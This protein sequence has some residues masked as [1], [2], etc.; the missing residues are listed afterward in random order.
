[1]IGA[2]AGWPRSP[3]TGGSLV[4]IGTDSGFSPL[5]LLLPSAI[6]MIFTILIMTDSSIGIGSI[7]IDSLIA[8]PGSLAIITRSFGMEIPAHV[9]GFL[10]VPPDPARASRNGLAPGPET[11]PL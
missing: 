1:M 10:A 11:V 6:S 7:T 4:A 3:G 5:A 2:R 9:T 8:M